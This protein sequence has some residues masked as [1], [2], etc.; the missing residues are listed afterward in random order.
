MVVDYSLKSEAAQLYSTE[1]FCYY[2]ALKALFKNKQE[3]F[4]SL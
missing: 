4:E 3:E 1:R 2:A